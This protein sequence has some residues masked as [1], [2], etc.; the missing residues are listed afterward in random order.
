MTKKEFLSRREVMLEC[1]YCDA[2]FD[3]IFGEDIVGMFVYEEWDEMCVCLRDNGKFVYRAFGKE[4]EWDALL[5]FEIWFEGL[6]MR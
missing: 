2:D 4:Y 6:R 1:G 3:D 5:D